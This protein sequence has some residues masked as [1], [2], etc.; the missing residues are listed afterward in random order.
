MFGVEIGGW[1]DS[2]CD[3]AL[4]SDQASAGGYLLLPSP[5]LW[6]TYFHLRLRPNTAHSR[7]AVFRPSSSWHFITESSLHGVDVVATAAAALPTSQPRRDDSACCF[8]CLYL[9]LRLSVS[10]VGSTCIALH[11][12]VLPLDAVVAHVWK[13]RDQD[14]AR[15]A[16]AQCTGEPYDL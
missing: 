5:I 15:W 1:S 3:P 14:T 12:C 16:A 10:K 7:H 8:A 2:Q 4:R 6:F 13:P 11:P 9:C